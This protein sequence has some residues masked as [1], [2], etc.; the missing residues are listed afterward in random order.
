MAENKT[1]K[2]DMKPRFTVEQKI[3][4]LVNKYRVYNVDKDGKKTDLMCF[5]QQ[6]RLAFKEK[7]TF[8]AD[9]KKTQV[10]F[11]LRAEKVV[12]VHGRYYI[13]DANSAK[14]GMFNKDFAKSLANSTWYINKDDQHALAITEKSSFTAT[15][16]RYA[17]F[18]PIVGD[19]VDMV[20]IFIK[21]HFVFSDL[22][23][24][25]IVGEYVKTTLF[26][27]H[28]TFMMDDTAYKNNDWRILVAMAVALDALQGR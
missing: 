3:N 18:I 15:M 8:Y 16:R 25:K 27:D 4:I 28:Y 23:S 24:K 21:Y 14:V 11:T 20:F 1:Q 13:E 6:K 12:D 19:I 5:V 7:I 22:T 26:R 2:T 10:L 17:G 9:E